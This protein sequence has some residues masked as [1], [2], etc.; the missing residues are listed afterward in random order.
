MS[1]K[2]QKVI[3]GCLASFVILL[4][5]TAVF[6]SIHRIEKISLIGMTNEKPDRIL[7][8]IG[9]RPG[10]VLLAS[11]TTLEARLSASNIVSQVSFKKNQLLIKL[12]Q[13]N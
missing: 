1:S 6:T 8:L 2:M 5:G 4:A 3:V 10:E 13:S 12:K 9:F 7:D 11:S